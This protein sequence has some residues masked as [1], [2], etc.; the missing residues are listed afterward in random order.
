MKARD[1]VEK[2][3]KH[4]ATVDMNHGKGSHMTVRLGD[5]GSTLPAPH[6]DLQIGIICR[7]LRRLGLPKTVLD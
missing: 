6:K 7:I 4:G 1:F 2:L 5:K 3:R